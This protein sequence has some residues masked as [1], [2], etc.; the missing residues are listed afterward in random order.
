MLPLYRPSDTERAWATSPEPEYRSPFRRDYARLLHCPAFRRLQGKTQLFPGFESD[1]FRNRLTHSLEVA[2]IAKSIAVRLNHEDEYLRQHPLNLDLIETAALAHDLGHPPFGHNGERALDACMRDKGGFEGNAQTLRI[3]SRLEKKEPAVPLGPDPS[4]GVGLNVTYRT[5]GSVLKYDS[6][7]P[8]QRPGTK[9]AKGYYF[10][11]R[12]LVERIKHAVCPDGRL[13]PGGFKTIECQIMDLAD[14]IA[15]STYDLEDAFKTGFVTPIQLIASVSDDTIVA[16]LAD[17]TGLLQDDILEQ[18]MDVFQDR[19]GALEFLGIDPED[20]NPANKSSLVV[21]AAEMERASQNLAQHGAI[22]TKLTSELVNEYVEGVSVAIDAKS[23]SL[24]KV[25]LPH[26]LQQRVAI[27][28]H[29]TYELVIQTP[30]LKTVEYRGSDI[31]TEL[32]DALFAPGGEL[33]LPEDF[34]QRVRGTTSSAARGRVVCDFIAGM[35]DRYAVE[36]YGR[37]NSDTPQTVFKPL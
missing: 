1:F 34:G 23:P 11:E 22:R 14:D 35:T 9:L 10:S 30:S 19:I 4:D 16:T 5:L 32:F 33:L 36:F 31:V 28:K 29:L 20:I 2:Q 3:L 13:A 25:T 26:R 15:Y 21:L 8:L 6:C 37:L 17:K 18:V 7:I 12:C 27:L 24:S